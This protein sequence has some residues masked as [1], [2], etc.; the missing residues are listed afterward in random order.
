MPIIAAT[1]YARA[2]EKAFVLATMED[3]SGFNWL[4][5]RSAGEFVRFG[6][7]AVAGRTQPGE[8]ES[9]L[10]DEDN[11]QLQYVCHG[12][13]EASGAFVATMVTDP[14][15]PA[16]IVYRLLAQLLGRFAEMYG[17]KLRGSPPPTKDL[18]LDFPPLA[19][20]LAKYQKPEDAD[21]A[22]A[23]MK[24]IDETKEVMYKTIDQV[25]RRGESIESIMAKS[26][27]LSSSSMKFYETSKKTR[28]CTIL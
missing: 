8:C 6:C 23:I 20:F 22:F 4:Y 21:K 13:A 3:L 10:P 27:D 19:E 9:I 26:E 1:I 17:G 25:L 12:H 5:R 14:K 2:P 18:S 7:R 11:A 28:C 16:K 24:E 15:Y